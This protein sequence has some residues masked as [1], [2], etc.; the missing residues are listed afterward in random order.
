MNRVILLYRHLKKKNK[1]RNRR[2]KAFKDKMRF[3][4]AASIVPGNEMD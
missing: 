4:V 2:N 3:N 1:I